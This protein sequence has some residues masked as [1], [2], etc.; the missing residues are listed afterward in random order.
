MHVKYQCINTST[1]Y[2]YIFSLSCPINNYL[3]VMIGCGVES[4]K[5]TQTQHAIAYM[6]FSREFTKIYRKCNESVSLNTSWW[7]TQYYTI[8]TLSRP[9]FLLLFLILISSLLLLINCWYS[10]D[11]KNQQNFFIRVNNFVKVSMRLC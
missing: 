7:S 4:K 10:H 9:Q 11:F 6:P 3:E 5:I 8:R 1:I 2:I